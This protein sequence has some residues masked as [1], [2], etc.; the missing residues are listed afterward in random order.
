[1]ESFTEKNPYADS[2]SSIYEWEKSM[3]GH[4]DGLEFDDVHTL[5]SINGKEIAII[6][7]N[8]GRTYLL[9]REDNNVRFIDSKESGIEAVVQAK[10]LLGLV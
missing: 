3:E 8:K 4:V 6:K 10:K 5:Q 9:S 1:M 7:S 2:F